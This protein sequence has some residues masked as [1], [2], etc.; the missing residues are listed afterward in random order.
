[1]AALGTRAEIVAHQDYYSCPLSAKQMPDAELDLKLA[2]VLGDTLAP[3]AIRLPNADG[4]CDETDAPVAMGFTYTVDLRA[5]DQSGQSHTW[6]ER[7]L[8]VRSLAFAASQEKSLRQRVA[9]AVTELNALD[10]RKQGKPRLPDAA[11]ASQAAAAI[12]AKHRVEG[13]LTVTV[14]TDVH[15]HVKRRPT[16]RAQR[17]RCAASACV[18]VRRARRRLSPTPCSAWAGASMRPITP[19]RG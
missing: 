5:S 9:R 3:S 10:E 13:L 2:P 18:C 7:R 4:A 1:M 14:T 17:Q 11:A 16:A 19:L 8:V 15:E 12:L 6:Q